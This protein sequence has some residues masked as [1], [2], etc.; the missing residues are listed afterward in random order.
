M[1]AFT[2]VKEYAYVPGRS[3]ALDLEILEYAMAVTFAAISYYFVEQ[4]F[5]KI[6]D[7]LSVMAETREKAPLRAE[8]ELVLK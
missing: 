2:W 5:L 6:K 3:E 1:L 4:P 8:G 7:R